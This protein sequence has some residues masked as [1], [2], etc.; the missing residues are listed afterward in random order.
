[1]FINNNYTTSPHTLGAVKS[2]TVIIIIVTG[3]TTGETT[4]TGTQTDISNDVV[5][6]SIITAT[7]LTTNNIINT[8]NTVNHDNAKL[9][10][11]YNTLYIYKYIINIYFQMKIL[12]QYI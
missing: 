10:G 6:P 8:V 2:S 1:M 7:D 12:N 11:K 9:T 5:S 4:I 3:R